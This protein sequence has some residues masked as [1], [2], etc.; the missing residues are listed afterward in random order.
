MSSVFPA[1]TIIA[2]RCAHLHTHL[3]THTPTCELRRHGW[4]RGPWL[5]RAQACHLGLGGGGL[6]SHSSPPISVRAPRPRSWGGSGQ[7][8]CEYQRGRR[9]PGRQTD[10]PP[11]L[12][13]GK[14][15]RAPPPHCLCSLEP[16]VLYTKAR[17]AACLFSWGQGNAFLAPP[18]LQTRKR[19]FG[20]AALIYLSWKL[21][22][23][24]VKPP[25][26]RG[27]GPDRLG[28]DATWTQD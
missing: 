22:G 17:E 10:R 12:G 9:D 15:G 19:M 24:G 13:L 6:S 21:P 20:R 16:C 5:G 3:H 1:A 11:L 18:I 8:G 23:N 2:P 27:A 7:C 26:V 28:D 25:R 14:P 4:E